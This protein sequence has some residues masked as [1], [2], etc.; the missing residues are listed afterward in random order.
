MGIRSR[1]QSLPA[2]LFFVL[3]ALSL[4]SKTRS[5]NKTLSPLISQSRSTTTTAFA[6]AAAAATDLWLVYHYHHHHYYLLENTPVQPLKCVRLQAA[7][8]TLPLLLTL[9]SCRTK[10][11]R[12]LLS[13]V[14][15][16]LT[17]IRALL[18]PLLTVAL[19]NGPLR[20]EGGREEGRRGREGGGSKWMLNR[21]QCKTAEIVFRGWWWGCSDNMAAK[22]CCRYWLKTSK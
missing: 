21:H 4:I 12:L 6:A 9:D 16:Q 7:I 10:R 11:Y 5:S 17:L 14:S 22:K 2:G 8:N 15:F 1:W 3:I 19:I 13:S 20:M 18:P